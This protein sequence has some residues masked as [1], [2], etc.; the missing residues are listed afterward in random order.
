[1]RQF[2]PAL[3]F[4]L[5]SVVSLLRFYAILV[6]ADIVDFTSAAFDD[7]VDLSPLIFAAPIYAAI[8]TLILRHAAIYI[9]WFTSLLRLII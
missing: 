3:R 6:Y 1:L 4:F 8:W 2:S 9:C 7:H 5:F